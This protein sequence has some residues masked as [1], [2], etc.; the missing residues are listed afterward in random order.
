MILQQEANAF[1]LMNIR[2]CGPGMR[3]SNEIQ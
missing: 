2:F 3:N 1:L